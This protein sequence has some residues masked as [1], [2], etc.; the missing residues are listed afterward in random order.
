MI[1]P[2]SEEVV[3]KLKEQASKTKEGLFTRN[4]ENDELTVALGNKEHPVALEA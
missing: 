3:Q 4:M 2:G 1:N